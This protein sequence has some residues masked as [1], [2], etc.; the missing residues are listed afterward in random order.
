[1]GAF[2]INWFT[3]LARIVDFPREKRLENFMQ[4]HRAFPVESQI[5]FGKY[6]SLIKDRPRRKATV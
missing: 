4:L 2:V 3:R 1:M 6:L 5:G